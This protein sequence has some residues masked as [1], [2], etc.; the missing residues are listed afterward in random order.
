MTNQP[1]RRRARAD[2]DN[3][4]HGSS[5]ICRRPAEASPRTPASYRAFIDID[6]HRS[7]T[8]SVGR[9]CG[10]RRRLDTTT[11]WARVQPPAPTRHD[12]ELHAQQGVRSGSANMTQ[13][14]LSAATPVCRDLLPGLGGAQFKAPSLPRPGR[15]GAVEPG[16]QSRRDRPSCA[17]TPT[18]EASSV[19]HRKRK[20][21]SPRGRAPRRGSLAASDRWNAL[22]VRGL[23]REIGVKELFRAARFGAGLAGGAAPTG[24][25]ESA[26]R[27]GLFVAT[28]R[29]ALGIGWSVS[30]RSCREV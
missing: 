21:A 30:A 20:P 10:R 23:P 26:L 2:P 6:G 5:V 12:N 3:S 4:R 13:R 7:A 22:T 1:V 28:W 24:Y 15:S 29:V 11:S 27:V 8:R 14:E 18:S 25:R 19:P 16:N 9:A 17:S